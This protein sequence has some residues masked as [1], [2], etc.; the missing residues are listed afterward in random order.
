MASLKQE[1]SHDTGKTI[2]VVVKK[3]KINLVYFLS[4]E[5]CLETELTDNPTFNAD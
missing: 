4:N 1:V 2:T 5:L 3:P